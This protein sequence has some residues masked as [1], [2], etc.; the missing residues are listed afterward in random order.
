MAPFQERGEYTTFSEKWEKRR[1]CPPTIS[2][3]CGGCTSCLVKV[4]AIAGFNLGRD[5][6]Y[7]TFSL[8][9]N[10]PLVQIVRPIDGSMWLSPAMVNGYAVDP[11]DGMLS[12]AS[13]I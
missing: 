3:S 11:E 12:G 8:A 7:A 1:A 9:D 5:V 4:E 10:S 6:S 2:T 13:L